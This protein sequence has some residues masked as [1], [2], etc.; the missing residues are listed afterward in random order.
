MFAKFPLG[1]SLEIIPCHK[2]LVNH[3]SVSQLH[4]IHTKEKEEEREKKER[5]PLL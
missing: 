5:K 4:L 1:D 2:T 3:R